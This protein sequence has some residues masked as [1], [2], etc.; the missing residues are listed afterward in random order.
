M[1]PSLG[2]ALLLPFYDLARPAAHVGCV[3]T[4]AVAQM[5]GCAAVVHQR[6]GI[7][8]RGRANV[9]AKIA[10]FVIGWPPLIPAPKRA[11][12]V[13]AARLAVQEFTRGLL[14]PLLI[15]SRLFIFH[16]LVPWHG[17]TSGPYLYQRERKF[18][19]AIAGKHGCE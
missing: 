3:Y 17:P 15:L 9:P 1:A 5:I 2:P 11:L 19:R 18:G 16:R 7:R 13:R 14:D 10:A 6:P 12:R 8:A 4:H